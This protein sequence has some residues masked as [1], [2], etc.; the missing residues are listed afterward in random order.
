MPCSAP[1][2]N[3]E[4]YLKKSRLRMKFLTAWLGTRISHSGTR[5][6]NSGQK[7]RR[8]EMTATRQSASCEATLLWIR[9]GKRRRPLQGLGAR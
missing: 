8:W 4:N 9:P 5:I 3:E 1:V 6:F 7:R 2:S